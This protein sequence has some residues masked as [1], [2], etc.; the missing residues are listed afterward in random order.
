MTT[1]AIALDKLRNIGIV[2][3]IDAG[4][5][6]T[7]ERILFYTG[8]VHRIGEVDEQDAEIGSGVGKRPVR[9][10]EAPRVA[11]GD[12]HHPAP[13]L[14]GAR[15][16]LQQLAG[17]HLAQVRGT[18]E[19]IA[20]GRHVVV[21]EDHEDP[22]ARPEP[23]ELTPQ[24]AHAALPADEVAGDRDEVE[25]LRR[26]PVHGFPQSAAVQRDRAEVEVRDVQDPEAVE[27]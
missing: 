20:R 25:R 5:T 11:P 15:C 10:A 1:T 4:K 7:T 23:R 16:V 27:L 2:A 3:H 13:D 18:A 22:G 26:C 21:S 9:L 14:E 17:L 19:R 8:R 6:T 12:L 24:R